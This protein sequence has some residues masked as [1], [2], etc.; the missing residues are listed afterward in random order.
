VLQVT[1]ASFLCSHILKDA[2][3][4]QIVRSVVACDG[5]PPTRSGGAHV[6]IMPT[7][8]LLAYVQ[9]GPQLMSVQDVALVCGTLT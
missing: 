4:D 8:R 3:C 2:G 5:A 6:A 9:Y 7:A 1:R